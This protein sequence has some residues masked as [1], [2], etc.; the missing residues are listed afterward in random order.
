M[1]GEANPCIFVNP[2]RDS[3]VNLNIYGGIFETETCTS[4]GWY[5]VINIQDQSRANCKVLI[6]G[7]IFVNY[8]PATGDNTGA[9]DDTFVAPGYKSVKTT[10]N[11]K[12][13]WEVIPE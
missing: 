10:Y 5:P 4:K 1:N 13:A 8:D 2:L 11:G 12:P 6:Y 9:A 7:G 3:K